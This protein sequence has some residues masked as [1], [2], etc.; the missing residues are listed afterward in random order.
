MDKYLFTGFSADYWNKYGTSW[1]ASLNEFSQ[2]DGKSIVFSHDTLPSSAIEKLETSGVSVVG[3]WSEPAAG[4]R[5]LTLLMAEPFIK[6]HPGTYFHWD[7]DAYFQDSVLPLYESGTALVICGTGMIGGQGDAWKT[8]FN[9]YRLAQ[10]V[11]PM[12]A[13]QVVCELVRCTPGLIKKEADVW[14][15]SELELLNWD[16]GFKYQNR[17][18]PVVHLSKFKADPQVD[19]FTFGS[20]YPTAYRKWRGCHVPKTVLS[21]QKVNMPPE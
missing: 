19:E 13:A 21:N 20:K 7:G 15:F 5:D 18:V 6:K 9:F 2:F 8:F 17:L 3:P 11:R 16:N 10:F 4:G 14:N 1:L 12:N